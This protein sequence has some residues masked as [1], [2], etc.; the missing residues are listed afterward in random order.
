MYRSASLE[1]YAAEHNRAFN[2]RRIK[3]VK[4]PLLFII[5]THHHEGI[6][7]VSNQGRALINGVLNDEGKQPATIKHS[8]SFC[9]PHVAH[10]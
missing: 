9:I 6:K 2:R 3:L 8:Y 1:V 7:I 4:A 5:W 10:H